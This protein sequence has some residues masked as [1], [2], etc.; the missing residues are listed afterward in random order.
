MK[1]DTRVR[2]M[3]VLAV[4]VAAAM[5]L[6]F[7]ESRLPTFVPIPGV[8]IGLANIAVVFA[9]YR[10]GWRSA[11]AVSLARVALS[12][13]LFGSVASALYSLC[14]AALSLCA[15]GLVRRAPHLSCVGVSVVGGVCHNVGQILAAMLLLGTPAVLSYLPLLFLSGTLTGALVGIAAGL[16]VRRTDVR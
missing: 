13:L 16:L 12:A 8:K 1:N 9:L 14:G 3:T 15:M 5:V 11:G 4:T 6:S 7:V 10:L 2:R